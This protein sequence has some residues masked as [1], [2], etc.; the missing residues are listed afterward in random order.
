MYSLFTESVNHLA[1]IVFIKH[2]QFSG[3]IIVVWI[4]QVR[5]AVSYGY[6]QVHKDRLNY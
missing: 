3:T 2:F 4:R 1:N 6:I 5:F